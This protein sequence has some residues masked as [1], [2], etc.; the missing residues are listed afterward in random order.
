MTSPYSKTYPIVP[1]PKCPLCGHFIPNDERPGEYPG[2]LSRRDRTVEI[3][4]KCGE[5]EAWEDFSRAV[6]EGRF[7]D[8]EDH[9]DLLGNPI[10]DREE[11]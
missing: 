9:L 10:E 7:S 6:A 8:E 11:F 3:C 1:P 4:S 5:R 2:A